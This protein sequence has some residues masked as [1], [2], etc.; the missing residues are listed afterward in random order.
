MEVGGKN[1]L[2]IKNN[3][4]TCATGNAATFRAIRYLVTSNKIFDNYIYHFGVF[5]LCSLDNVLNGYGTA[6]SFYGNLNLPC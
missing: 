1:F 4:P 5:P 6:T 2:V 3:K